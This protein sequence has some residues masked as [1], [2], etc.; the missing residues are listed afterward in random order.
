M[1]PTG[2][3]E[4]TWSKA[5]FCE[6][7]EVIRWLKVPFETEVHLSP[8]KKR[9]TNAKESLTPGGCFSVKILSFNMS[10]LS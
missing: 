7:S 2:F 6:H 8:T 9:L 4:L 3:S 5:F 10:G 1:S